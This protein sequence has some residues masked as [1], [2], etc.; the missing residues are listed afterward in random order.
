MTRA[1]SNF[2]NKK[3]AFAFVIG[4]EVYDHLEAVMDRIRGRCERDQRY[5]YRECVTPQ[6]GA[7]DGQSAA[8]VYRPQFRFTVPNFL[9][10]LAGAVPN[11]H[12]NID[13][14]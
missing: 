1:E 12:P 7:P 6:I 14:L 10:C 4:T 11:S 5:C 13:L 9:D 8:S 2:P 3:D